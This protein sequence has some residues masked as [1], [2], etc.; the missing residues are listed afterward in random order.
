MLLIILNRLFLDKGHRNYEAGKCRTNPLLEKVNLALIK[1]ESG[2]AGLYGATRV[3]GG[4][5]QPG[6]RTKP[7]D[8]T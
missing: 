1:W 5:T 2:L 8:T 6:R 7:G 4:G 3:L